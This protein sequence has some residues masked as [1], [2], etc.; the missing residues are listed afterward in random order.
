MAVSMDLE[1]KL[2]QYRRA[3]CGQGDKN[4]HRI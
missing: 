4:E 2:M 3:A 1:D